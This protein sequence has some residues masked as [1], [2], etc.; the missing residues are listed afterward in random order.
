MKNFHTSLFTSGM[1]TSK[2]SRLIFAFDSLKKRAEST[3]KTAKKTNEAPAEKT[4]VKQLKTKADSA[5]KRWSEIAPKQGHTLGFKAKIE[6]LIGL[7]KG[8]F[9]KLAKGKWTKQEIEKFGK[10]IDALEVKAKLALKV[11][12]A[13]KKI[14]KAKK[15]VTKEKVQKQLT[16]WIENVP[17]VKKVMNERLLHGIGI[18]EIFVSKNTDKVLAA[19]HK[20]IDRVGKKLLSAKDLKEVTDIE[21]SILTK[22][23]EMPED[24]TQVLS[25]LE[26]H[27]DVNTTV[28]NIKQKAKEYANAVMLILDE[29][30]R[31]FIEAG[32]TLEGK[33]KKQ[34]E[35][36]MAKLKS[37]LKAGT[38]ISTDKIIAET[39]TAQ[40][41][42]IATDI[43]AKMEGSKKK[44]LLQ[45]LI[46]AKFIAKETKEISAEVFVEA[47]GQINIGYKSLGAG[48]KKAQALQLVAK[49]IQ[50]AIAG[51]KGMEM[52]IEGKADAES[53]KLN[54]YTLPTIRRLQ[55]LAKRFAKIPEE[56]RRK[57]LD[58]SPQV[59]HHQMDIEYLAILSDI[60]EKGKK[61]PLVK[62]LEKANKEERDKWFGAGGVLNTLL[63]F[64]RAENIAGDISKDDCLIYQDNCNV[65][66]KA[67]GGREV[68]A[69]D[70]E[71][72]IGLELTPKKTEQVTVTQES[73][74]KIA[75]NKDK[76]NEIIKKLGGRDL[77]GP[78]KIKGILFRFD[79]GQSAETSWLKE[80]T[81]Q[82]K[83]IFNG[84]EIGWSIDMTP[85]YKVYG[86]AT[87]EGETHATFF[88]DKKPKSDLE[89]FVRIETG[90]I[91]L[92]EMI[93]KLGGKG[94]GGMVKI[95]GLEF[96]LENEDQID[97][98]LEKKEDIDAFTHYNGKEIS[99]G[100]KL[101]I[102][103]VV[104]KYAETTGETPKKKYFSKNNP[105]KELSA[106]VNSEKAKIDNK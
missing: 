30:G 37:M 46:D 74:K 103:T 65:L 60:S 81:V 23:A 36:W 100:L 93:K 18:V 38:D 67:A 90:K 80:G 42:I 102:P 16:E 4:T 89:N 64:Q 87:H 95:S 15:L 50:K 86:H 45:G 96:E 98:K 106:Y 84:K 53:I 63:A 62:F 25:R 2:E 39:K 72:R 6:G 5:A 31:R 47:L 73:A 24:A 71:S 94:F 54:Q 40:T 83:G 12:E 97:R 43:L 48:K 79:Y 56:K 14:T 52:K 22:P 51:R 1:K 82:A 69:K 91:A 10:D 70:R 58:K 104:F 75:K 28:E 68:R 7:L 8:K 66:I 55:G 11:E 85:P 41:H 27:L 19:T 88:E 59:E 35:A 29:T 33:A 26:Y 21:A 78:I 13:Q 61:S 17:E 3:K 92:E 49:L 57:L 99:W 76:V 9:E 34:F 44:A 105:K 20:A 101:G 77:D 32:V